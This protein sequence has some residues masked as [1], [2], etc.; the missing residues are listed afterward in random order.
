MN[1]ILRKLLLQVYDRIYSGLNFVLI[2]RFSAQRTHSAIVQLLRTLDR[3]ATAICVA[4][5]VNDLVDEHQPT[6]VGGVL[7]SR[8]LILAAGMVKGDGYADE[9]AALRAVADP[10]RNILPGWRLMPA[11]VGPVEYGSFTRHP[12]LGNDGS[13][14]WRHS[15][16]RSTQNRIGLKNPGAR[17]AARFL[18][19]RKNQLPREYGI[20]IAVSPAVSDA[21]QQAR[22]VIESLEFFLDAGLRPS[23]FTL[24]LSCPNTDDDPLGYQLDAETRLLCGAFIRC[25]DSRELDIPL[26]GEAQSHARGNTISFADSHFS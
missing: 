10:R 7:L 12:R 18:A 14:V 5:V 15:S 23:W 19:Q 25:L 1:N 21:D 3:F 11:L 6:Q 4:K 8:P 20:N 22:E 17:A 16:S 9:T 13:V 24:N 26:W 2:F